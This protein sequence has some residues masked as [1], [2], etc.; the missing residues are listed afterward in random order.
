MTSVLSMLQ[1][2]RKLEAARAAPR[3]PIE[4]CWGSFGAFEDQT[5]ALIDEGKLDRDDMRAVLTAL[6][7]W[8][9]DRVWAGWR[10]KGD[11]SPEYGR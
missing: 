2:V 6:R 5:L 10:Y 9:A 7:R 3:S 1:R 4:V 8:H 11:G